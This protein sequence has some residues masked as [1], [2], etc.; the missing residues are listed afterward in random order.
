MGPEISLVLFFLY[1]FDNVRCS[2]FNTSRRIGTQ[3]SRNLRGKHIIASL[4]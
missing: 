3:K 4:V 2:V 1:V